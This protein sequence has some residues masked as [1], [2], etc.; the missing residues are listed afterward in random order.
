MPKARA[1]HWPWFGIVTAGNLGTATLVKRV[2]ARRL[3]ALGFVLLAVGIAGLALAPTL[4]LLLVV[5]FCAGLSQGISYPVLMGLSIQFVAQDRRATAMGLH[6]A[7][8]AVGMFAGPWLSG[9]LADAI[10]IQPML[11]ATAFACL[12]LSLLGTRWLEPVQGK[13]DENGGVE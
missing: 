1:I 9:A 10:G 5:Q 4:P 13:K 8:Y 12:A 3:A 6:Q 2:G 7:V 11:G